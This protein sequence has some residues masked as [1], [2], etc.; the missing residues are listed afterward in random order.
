MQHAATDHRQHGSPF[1][2]S[3]ATTGQVNYIVRTAAKPRILTNV[4]GAPDRR[5][6]PEHEARTVTV[7]DARPLAGALS[8][9][10]EAFRLVASPTAVA[11]LRDE[12][13]VTTRYYK[14]V[15]N[16]IRS[17]TGA[18]EVLIFDHTIRA[19]DGEETVRKPVV[20]V[21]G[22]YT[23]KSGPQRVRDLVPE[24]EQARWFAGRYGVVNVWRP[25]V[26]PVVS[27]P[28][29]FVD[30]QTLDEAD[31]VAVDLVYPD[32][33]GEIFGFAW[34]PAHRWY[35]FPRMTRDEALLIRTYDSA[36]DGR[37][38]FSAHSSF[39]D[40]DTPADAP[41]RQSIEVRALV[42]YPD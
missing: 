24:A 25:I 11:D 33:T 23:P 26:E 14:E 2:A 5:I 36:E 6:Y 29:A 3:P 42:R 41:P 16:L 17:E 35:Y 19:Q 9:D 7:H 15:E 37:A 22:D 30:A 34:N 28:L 40:P 31:H 38:R 39:E 20:N 12:D 13:A 4:E 21:H 18:V 27:R 1:A 32:R 10:R 8:L